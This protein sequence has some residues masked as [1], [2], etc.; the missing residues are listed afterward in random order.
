MNQSTLEL[1]A[2][3]QCTAFR[4]HISGEERTGR[5]CKGDDAQYVSPND[6]PRYWTIE[7]I[8][9]FLRSSGN[10]DSSET[11]RGAYLQVLSILV[12]IQATLNIP[13]LHHLSELIAHNNNDASLPWPVAP[14]GFTDKASFHHFYKLQWRFCPIILNRWPIDKRQR[15]ESSL[16]AF[17]IYVPD[18]DPNQHQPRHVVFKT[19]D[20][21]TTFDEEL[22][23]YHALS[24][25]NSNIVRNYGSFYWIS[26]TNIRHSTIILELA[27]EGS[28]RDL[29][30]LNDPPTTRDA[31]LKFWEGFIDLAE[32]LEALHN[33]E[34][35]EGYSIIHQDLKPSNVLVFR[36]KHR[37]GSPFQF[38][39][40]DFGSSTVKWGSHSQRNSGPDTGAGKTY[41]PPELHLN[42]TVDYSVKPTVDTWALGC[43]MMEASYWLAF[44]EAGR[45]RFREERKC[46][47]SQ[48]HKT[49]G[50]SDTFHDGLEV[51]QCVRDVPQRLERDGRRCDDITPRIAQYVLDACL[52]REKARSLSHQVVQHVK[53]ILY[54]KPPTGDQH[55]F[56]RSAGRNSWTSLPSLNGH[57]HD[58]TTSTYID[59]GSTSEANLS[60]PPHAN[61]HDGFRS[62]TEAPPASQQLSPRPMHRH[63]N[64]ENT[65]TAAHNR[66]AKRLKHIHQWTTN[67]RVATKPTLNLSPYQ[68]PPV[69]YQ[70]QQLPSSFTK[71]TSS[72]SAQTP[73]LPAVTADEV[74]SW[75]KEGK[76]TGVSSTLPGWD[77][78]QRTLGGRDYIIVID[79]ST[80]MQNHRGEVGKLAKVLSYLMKH[81][82][83]NGVEV[84]FTSNP[85]QKFICETS[86][87][88]ESQ[89]SRCFNHGHN[90]HC[91][92][93]HT[94]DTVFKDVKSKL[95]RSGEGHSSSSRHIRDRLTGAKASGVSIYALTSG[96]WDRSEEGTCGVEKPIES[97]IAFMKAHELGRTE[98]S[99]QFVRFGADARG[100]KRL[101]VLDD[102]LPEKEANL[103]L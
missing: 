92:M 59:P 11:V 90:A 85:K 13:S 63:D 4:T 22:K 17:E 10:S 67:E 78:I 8:E 76:K 101:T 84:Y 6:L 96:V 32:G 62:G 60:P 19:Y 23:A 77:S 37:A 36:K 31:I 66:A 15:R 93:E 100:I 27:E 47:T 87:K 24:R 33:Y 70:R 51:L 89:L 28:L 38:K 75:I 42:H 83:P 95:L 73:S 39:I 20:D 12:W 5:Q 74:L 35:H 49:L 50:C 55:S 69:I 103:H 98:A 45:Q 21:T 34:D 86:T 81:L 16:E 30:R 65:T 82:D 57:P 68:K 14:R 25:K 41:G 3:P 56:L 80:F 58:P 7:R 29:Y 99:I 72:E 61:A 2:M 88:V 46:E 94:L 44:G 79:N 64:S 18:S 91:Q 102:K 97:L 71:S 53:D 54:A 43:I 48:D 52:I 26:D 9:D 40:G 1:R